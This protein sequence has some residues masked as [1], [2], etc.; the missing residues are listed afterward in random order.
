M[1][2]TS[3]FVRPGVAERDKD[4]F[5]DNLGHMKIVCEGDMTRWHPS[6]HKGFNF[7]RTATKFPYPLK[8]A[9]QGYEYACWCECRARDEIRSSC[10][11]L[12]EA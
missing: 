2:T 9:H 10:N 1:A 8:K 3:A 11:T 6:R 5:N 4:W 12:L 7:A